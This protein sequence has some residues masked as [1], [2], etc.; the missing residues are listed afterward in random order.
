MSEIRDG[1]PAYPSSVAVGSCG[2][3]YQGQY[4][5]MSLRAYIATAALAG[6][7]ANPEEILAA[8]IEVIQAALARVS[9]GYADALIAELNK[10]GEAS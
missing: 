9:V 6:L 2:D 10:S 5:G 4:F 8:P 1:G 3:V 7:L